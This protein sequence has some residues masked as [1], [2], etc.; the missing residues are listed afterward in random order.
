[1]A[2]ISVFSTV[3]FE[4]SDVNAKEPIEQNTCADIPLQIG[5][6]SRSV[7]GLLQ[8][9]GTIPEMRV[10]RMKTRFPT[11]KWRHSPEQSEPAANG[12]WTESWAESPPRE[13]I[14]TY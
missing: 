9:C 6:M 10:R 4:A 11:Y 13:L 8:G 5:L 1:M 7:C 3:C 14:P 12:C 2:F